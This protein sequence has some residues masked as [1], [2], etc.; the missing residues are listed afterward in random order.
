LIEPVFAQ[1]TEPELVS[2][3]N[4]G[5]IFTTL[6]G[7]NPGGSVKDHMVK[8]ELKERLARGDLKAGDTVVEA[9][10]G[11]T[12]R[13][14]AFY[15]RELGLRCTLLI[16]AGLSS[17]IQTK[18]IDLGAR[19]IPIDPAIAFAAL[20]E[21]VRQTGD[22]PLRQFSNPHL[23][24]HY[25][26]FAKNVLDHLRLEAVLGAVGTGHSLAGF[27]SVCRERGIALH[28]AEP[29]APAS[30]E[31]VRNLDSQSLGANDP[32][33]QSWFQ[34]EVL[35]ERDFFPRPVLATDKGLIEI[36][37]SFRMVLGAAIRLASK[38]VSHRL[39]ALGAANRIV[40]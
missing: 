37:P 11:S 1:V 24:R 17:S 14:L 16:P 7:E 6:E 3:L 30:V 18:L 29:L 27:R 36:T 22:W 12:G 19:L 15:S 28:S 34:R 9:T 5:A 38:E 8:G 13:S 32:V 35:P 20:E 31:G 39:F 33:N 2:R 26:S 25:H 40:R 21:H 23:T 4:G 10:A